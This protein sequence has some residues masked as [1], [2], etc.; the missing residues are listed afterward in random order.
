MSQIQSPNKRFMEFLVDFVHSSSASES[1]TPDDE[2]C[3]TFTYLDYFEIHVKQSE[4]ATK[5][6]NCM[7]TTQGT[8]SSDENKVN[9]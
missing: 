7:F 9:T 6:K 2:T 4:Y 1:F 5:P 8:I 3:I